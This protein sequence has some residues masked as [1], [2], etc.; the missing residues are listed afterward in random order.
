MGKKRSKKQPRRQSMGRLHAAWLVLR[1]QA[2]T[3]QQMASEWA[4]IQ[5]T[6]SEMF[7]RFNT[8]AARLVRAEK[9]MMKLRLEEI[10]GVEREV[11]VVGSHKDEVRRR[12]AA[13]RFP[14]M[15]PPTAEDTHEP[16][17]QGREVSG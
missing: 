3:P 2:L 15:R 14:G 13:L 5:T 6:A 16:T 4:E 7:N 11:P 9:N 1:G 12:V 10:D 17:N 8:L